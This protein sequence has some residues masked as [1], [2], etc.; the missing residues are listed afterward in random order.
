MNYDYDGTLNSHNN[1]THIIHI[2][3]LKKNHLFCEVITR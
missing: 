2:V 1:I 3:I